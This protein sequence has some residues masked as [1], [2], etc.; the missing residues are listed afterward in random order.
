MLHTV[1]LSFS[2]YSIIPKIHALFHVD[3]CIAGIFEDDIVYSMLLFGF[4]PQKRRN[5]YDR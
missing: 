3:C 2:F 1:S 5:I 4:L